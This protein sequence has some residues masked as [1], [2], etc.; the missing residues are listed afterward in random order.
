MILNFE[1]VDSYSIIK[2]VH[3]VISGAFLI[4]AV[5]LIIRSVRGIMTVSYTHLRAHET[6]HDLVC[7]LL[8]EKRR[9]P[10]RTTQCSSS[11][12][13][14]LYKRQCTYSNKRGLPDLRCLSYNSICTMDK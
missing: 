11:A 3:T 13:S 8:L 2:Y 5:W 10:P 9:R 6:R 4:F 14:D 12:A 1:I 7:R